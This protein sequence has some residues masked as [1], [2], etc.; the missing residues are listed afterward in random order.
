MPDGNDEL[1]KRFKEM[2]YEEIR[3]LAHDNETEMLHLEFKTVELADASHSRDKARLSKHLSGFANSAGGIL[4]WGLEQKKKTSKSAR[5]VVEKPIQNAKLFCSSLERLTGQATEPPVSGVLHKVVLKDANGKEGFVVSLI[6]Q[7]ESGPHMAKYGEVNHRYYRRTGETT[8]PMEHF[9]LDDMFGRR[10]RPVLDLKIELRCRRDGSSAGGGAIVVPLIKIENT[11]L[12]L[13]RFP[14][15]FFSVRQPYQVNAWDLAG[16]IPNPLD[17]TTRIVGD[18]KW[19]N[20]RG[21]IDDVVHPQSELPV[22]HLKEVKIAENDKPERIDN[23]EVEYELFAD[24]MQKKSGHTA[25][26]GNDLLEE[27]KKFLNPN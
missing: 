18:S 27:V 14:M 5:E 21:G 22:T 16:K 3:R 11:G 26:S 7:S 13:A 24:R 12:G 2:D 8:R 17:S 9:E 10:P 4:V 15:V 19:H 6:P 1:T 23:L 20:F 25:L